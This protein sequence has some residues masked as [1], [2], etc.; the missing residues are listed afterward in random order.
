MLNA[1]GASLLSP[2]LLKLKVKD[3]YKNEGRQEIEQIQDSFLKYC[4]NVSKHCDNVISRAELG[5]FPL[6]FKVQAQMIK[7]FLGIAQGTSNK[8]LDEAYASS[9]ETDSSWIQNVERFIKSN[10]FA[11]VFTKPCTVNKDTFYR[12]F[13]NKFKDMYVQDFSY[14][15]SSK[16]EITPNYI[17]IFIGTSSR[18]TWKK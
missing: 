11:N 6:K 17:L 8:L 12:I 3:N 13:T 5:K 2:I 14:S 10:G 15:T 18:T 7:Y 4:I 9:Q 16:T 1:S